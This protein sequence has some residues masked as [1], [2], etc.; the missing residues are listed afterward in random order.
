MMSDNSPT[1]PIFAR[2][3]GDHWQKLAPAVQSHYNLSPRSD[4]ELILEGVMSVY[5]PRPAITLL[6]MARL[7]GGLVLLREDNIPVQVKNSSRPDSEAIFWHRTFNV[8]G[9]KRSVTFRSQM[10]YAGGDEIVEYVGSSL[11]IK[12][13]VRMKIT[14]NEGALNFQSVG[15]TLKIGPVEMPIPGHLILGR[16]LITESAVGANEISMH[17]TIKHPLFG[18]IY[19]YG[20]QFCL[21]DNV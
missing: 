7:F 2:A 1:I 15:Y 20:G 19:S 21:P 18:E 9:R 5:Y 17:F 13:G 8:P 11:G 4:D 3:L 16:A 6:G 14:E 10:Q 12:L